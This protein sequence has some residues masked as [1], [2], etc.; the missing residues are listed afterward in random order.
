MRRTNWELDRVSGEFHRLRRSYAEQ[1][2]LSSWRESSETYVT[3][4]PAMQSSSTISSTDFP[5]LYQWSMSGLWSSDEPLP[6]WSWRLNGSVV[7]FVLTV[8][9]YNQ[10]HT[11]DARILLTLCQRFNS[12]CAKESLL[13]VWVAE[14]SSPPAEEIESGK[15]WSDMTG[16]SRREEKF[17]VHKFVRNFC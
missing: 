6:R 1:L 12:P 9:C 4:I 14:N 5:R 17:Q 3:W 8:I 10:S 13:S 15:T 11:L 7:F 16:G 2:R